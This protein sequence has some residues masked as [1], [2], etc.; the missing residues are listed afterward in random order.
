MPGI[1]VHLNFL[2]RAEKVKVRSRKRRKSDRALRR[3]QTNQH[4]MSI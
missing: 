4:F 3:M 2:T 1:N